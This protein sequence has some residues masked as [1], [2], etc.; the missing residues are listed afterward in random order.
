MIDS[1]NL[2]TAVDNFLDVMDALHG[3]YLDSCSGFVEM[4]NKIVMAQQQAARVLPPGTDQDELQMLYGKGDPNITNNVTHQTT[5]GEFKSR[6]QIG[7]KNHIR[8]AQL[9][10]VLVLV[11]GIT[12]SAGN[13]HGF[14][15]CG[16]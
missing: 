16:R 8:A 14:R 15:Y 3:H 11:L 5:Q 2:I 6:N 1:P 9:F 4:Y 13:R 10:I 7:G 12:P